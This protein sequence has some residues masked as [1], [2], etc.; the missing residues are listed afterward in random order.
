MARVPLSHDDAAPAEAHPSLHRH[1]VGSANPLIT[2]GGIP[3][4]VASQRHFSRRTLTLSL[5]A[6]GIVFG[7]IGTSPLYVMRAVFASGAVPFNSV[8]I[9]G[10]VS[11]IVWTLIA[12]VSGKYVLLVLRADNRGE[13]GIIAL[14]T[15]V[16]RVL[17]TSALSDQK[18]TR[19]R[20]YIFASVCG[21]FGA[22]LFFGDSVIT[23]AISVLSA[24]EG[25]SVSAPGAQH[26]IVPIALVLLTGL[27][28]IQRY[29]TSAVGKA[30]GPVML[31][32]FASFI[33]LGAPAIARY[34]QIARA[35]S[36]LEA[37]RFITAYPVAAFIAL[38]AIV[39]AL[40]GAEA[41]YADISH[42]GRL[43][44]QTAWFV[45]VLPALIVMYLGQGAL[46]I[47]DPAALHN[48]FFL[49][50]PHWAHI[51]LVIGAAMA[52][53]IASQAVISGAYSV[54]RQATRLGYLPH[55]RVVYTSQKEVGQIYMPGVNAVLFVAVA[56]VV[57]LFRSSEALSG[58][59]GLAVTTDFL[60]TT[61][62]LLILTH[63][64]WHWA[65]PVTILIGIVLLTLEVPLWAA[66]IIK[67][68]TGG[69]LPLSI[70]LIVF[71]LMS[72][73]HKG[74][75]V[76]RA[77]RASREPNLK[78]FLAQVAH[79]QPRRIPGT[80]VYLHSTVRTAPLPLVRNLHVTHTLHDHVVILSMKTLGVPHADPHQRVEI[81]HF[82]NDLP[83]M[84]HVIIHYGFKDERNPIEDLRD[85]ALNPKH[86]WSFSKAVFFTSHLELEADDTKQLRFID[87]ISRKVFLAMAH[88][89]SSPSWLR[90][91][92]ADQMVETSFRLAI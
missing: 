16:R 7:D 30:F 87:R 86:T 31:A 54:A 63:K 72:I 79:H 67:I 91:V 37:L 53:L 45:L 43:P 12:I 32:W 5:A 81:L 17:T 11:A 52:T 76:V 36:P 59:Y 46:L 55:L 83:G 66:N 19:S 65:L 61:S 23:P 10:V 8:T 18:R 64:A 14:A 9:T 85:S 21:V 2:T 84:Y 40:T 1:I 68:T 42:F 29:G 60:L 20:T 70:A 92:P 6:L 27:F 73:W 90:R 39:L 41:L 44:I 47:L 33:A 22:A 71:I 58:A 35:L 89:A 34:P 82:S 49:L 26:A 88:T 51:P 13:G 78:Y 24:V 74:E 25:I 80:A 77:A 38:G 50:A 4:V 3:R 56:A 69:W 15:L 28:A 62:L 75:D 57:L 48:P